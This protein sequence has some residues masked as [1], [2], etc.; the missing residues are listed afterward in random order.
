MKMG[1]DDKTTT[2]K[3][4]HGLY[5]YIKVIRIYLRSSVLG[6]QSFDF[7]MSI[8]VSGKNN[9]IYVNFHFQA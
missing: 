5:K 6:G 7:S 4:I 8:T 3:K 9:Y 2:W 1:Q